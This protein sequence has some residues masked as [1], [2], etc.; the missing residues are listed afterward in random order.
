MFPNSRG[1]KLDNWQRIQT[2]LMKA[3]GTTD[4]HRHDLRRTA[5]T[6]MMNLQVPLSTIDQ[7]LAHADPLQ[8]ENVSGA[9]SHY[10]RLGKVLKNIENPQATALN[11]L[12]EALHMIEAGELK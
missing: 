4:W 9:A 3:S 11:V 10:L 6:L 1:G 8:R 2:A 5:A 7:I 12:A